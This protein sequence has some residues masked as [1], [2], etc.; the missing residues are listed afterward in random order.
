MRSRILA[1]GALAALLGAC[2]ANIPAGGAGGAAGAAGNGSGV[3]GGVSGGGSC[4]TCPPTCT[5]CGP[6]S[7]AQGLGWSTRFPR[8]S[9]KQWENT[10]RDLLK[11]DRASGLS[12]SFTPDASTRFDTNTEENEIT[13][14]LR[15][16]YEIAA[17]ALA[18]QVART[19]AALAKI[20]PTAT[21]DTQA[22]GRAFVT[23]FG[24]RAFRRPLATEEVTAMTALFMKGAQL[25]GGDAV[26][27]GA[28]LTLRAFLQSPHLLYRAE[29]STTS[30]DNKIWL[31]GYEVATRLSYA[32]WNTMPSDALFT[33]AEAGE[34]KDAAGVERWARTMVDDPRAQ[35][36][37]VSFHE[38]L[39]RVSGYG[40]TLKDARLFPTFTRDLEPIL[41]SEA[42]LFFDDVTKAGGG[43]RDILTKPVTFVNNRT[44]PFYGVTGSFTAAM[45]R[46][47]L[48]A[49]RRA[50]ILTQ[51]GFLAK[52]GG[53]VQSDPI[54]RGVLINLNVLCEKIVPPPVLPPLPEQQPG[55]TNRERIDNHTK[56]CG[57]GCHDTRIN[58]IGFAFEHYDAI[59]AWR[60]TDNG[61]P[62]NSSATYNLD[63][64][65]LTYNDA[66]QLSQKLAETRR[67]HDCYAT[68]WLEY[69][70]GR[71]LVASAEGG[72][73]KI[74]ADASIG[75]A[76]AKA[77]LAKI[78][79]LDTFRARPVEVAP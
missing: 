41:Q 70:L 47:D 25:L 28:E 9:H 63:G 10:T 29:S 62:V 57:K 76:G 68:N 75:G 72:T 54:H 14:N 46:V 50:G 36:I 17:E 22:K 77:L 48:N 33:A 39:F 53:L 15:N 78:T 13:A 5:D 42:R 55:Q 64:Q 12:G 56:E 67:V 7:T 26:I 59:G 23:A 60:D 18:K 40:T 19:P 1:A 31:S 6:G 37:V 4:P 66:V 51:L 35:E 32:L 73:V 27:A 34:L 38:Q 58:P 24:K 21:G 74:V 44:A 2:T 30:Q 52:N 11:L 3:G 49:Q 71:K 43:I 69:A 45:Q 20:M 65:A 61:L 16:D 8:L 79:T